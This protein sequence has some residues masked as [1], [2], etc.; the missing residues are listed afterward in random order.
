MP[1]FSAVVKAY[2]IVPLKSH[3][4]EETEAFLRQSQAAAAAAFLLCKVSFLVVLLP[5]SSYQSNF[6]RFRFQPGK[7]AYARAGLILNNSIVRS[8]AER[9]TSELEL[10]KSFVS[11]IKLI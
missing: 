9:V 7:V 1:A 5:L 4:V 8:F 10:F 2:V 6:R 11:S 3:F